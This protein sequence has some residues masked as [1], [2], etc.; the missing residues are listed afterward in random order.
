MTFAAGPE[1]VSGVLPLVCSPGRSSDSPVLV[2]TP[3][4]TPEA[5]TPLPEPVLGSEQY[6]PTEPGEDEG[7]GLPKRQEELA[8]IDEQDEVLSKD[9]E[10][11]W[12]KTGFAPDAPGPGCVLSSEG[13]SAGHTSDSHSEEEALEP[14][15]ADTVGIGSREGAA[16]LPGEIEFAT[17]LIS[18]TVEG[19]KDADEKEVPWSGLFQHCVYK[20][21]HIGHHDPSLLN[22]GKL[23]CGSTFLKPGQSIEESSFVQL[24]GYPL[25]GSE[26][27]RCSKAF[28]NSGRKLAKFLKTN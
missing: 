18:A 17:N 23:C 27:L 1:T 13:D 14:L 21:I 20:T 5:L 28:A 3:V 11:S 6:E 7:F 26:C 9:S 4:V 2:A 19:N 8:D 12:E 24:S 15:I 22:K 10:G 25:V 16:F